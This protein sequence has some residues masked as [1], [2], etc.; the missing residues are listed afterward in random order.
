MRSFIGPQRGGAPDATATRGDGCPNAARNAAGG[1]G[2]LAATIGWRPPPPPPATATATQRLSQQACTKMTGLCARVH[3]GVPHEVG[4]FCGDF[5]QF[6]FLGRS[7][8]IPGGVGQFWTDSGQCRANVA[9]YG[10]SCASSGR[11][12][13]FLGKY[14]QFCLVSLADF[15]QMFGQIPISC[16]LRIDF[17][18]GRTWSQLAG[19]HVEIHTEVLQRTSCEH[20]GSVLWCEC[21]PNLN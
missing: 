18:I 3:T 5:G 9:T 19:R 14:W 12:W 4:Q 7:R 21:L 6:R 20:C 10:Q 8:R 1:R 13:S 17:G 16:Q 11:V 15:G 2:A